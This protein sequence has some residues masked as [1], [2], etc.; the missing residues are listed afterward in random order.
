MGGR[1]AAFLDRD[2]TLVEEVPYLHEPERVALVP[3]AAEALAGLAAAGFAL[4][5]VSNQAG[6]A[7]GRYPEAAVARV[8]RRLAEL[9]ARGGV[10]LDG[11]WYCPHHPDGTVPGYARACGCRKP[12][13]GMLLAAAAALGLDLRASVL[14]G[15]HPDDVGAAVA[16]G[17][18]PLFVATGRAADEPPPPGVRA[19]PSLAAAAAAVLLDAAGARKGPGPPRP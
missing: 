2:G 12:A 13:P 15:N 8:H 7:R 14:I 5:V 11:I 17:V 18:A 16:A 9:L 6:V 1:P 3:G 4:V 19:F 10:H